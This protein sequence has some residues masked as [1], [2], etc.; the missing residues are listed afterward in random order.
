MEEIGEYLQVSDHA[1]V[2]A[3][4]DEQADN[5]EGVPIGSLVGTI[6]IIVYTYREHASAHAVTGTCS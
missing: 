4:A 5:I 6:E 1:W 2:W 3:C